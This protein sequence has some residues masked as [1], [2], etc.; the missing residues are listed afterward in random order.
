MNRKNF[1]FLIALLLI[2]F[3]AGCGLTRQAIKEDPFTANMYAYDQALNWYVDAAE[4]Y[5][6]HY[7][8]ADEAIKAKWKE[9]INPVFKQ[10][11]GALDEWKK[12]LDKGQ[13]GEDYTE[14]INRLK[15]SIITYGL[16]FLK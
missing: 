12:T 4:T 7:Q 6:T 9:N 10:I 14:T 11:K 13:V 1:R 3:V 16:T 2:F 5:D 15:T 8:A